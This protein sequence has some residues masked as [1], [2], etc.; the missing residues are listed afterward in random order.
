MAISGHIDN[1]HG[2]LI[3]SG[4][5]PDFDGFDDFAQR[6]LAALDIRIVSKAFG[7]DRHQ[8]QLEFE[9]TELTLHFEL[10]SGSIW[11][12]LKDSSEPQLLSYFATII[13]QSEL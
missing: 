4:N 8:W 3:L 7:A 13:Q 1:D 10:Y 5:L 9:G 6:L 12:E 11:F 2:V